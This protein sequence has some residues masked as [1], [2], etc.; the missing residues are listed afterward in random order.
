MLLTYKNLFARDGYP[1][2]L[3]LGSTHQR[4]TSG[5]PSNAAFARFTC[6]TT[7]EGYFGTTTEG[8]PNG[9]IPPTRRIS[10]GWWSRIPQNYFDPPVSWQKVIYINRSTALGMDRPMVSFGSNQ[11]RGFYSLTNNTDN[12]RMSVE[13]DFHPELYAGQWFHT[14]VYIDLDDTQLVGLTWERDGT[15][16]TVLTPGVMQMFITTLDGVYRNTR[17]QREVVDSNLGDFISLDFLGGYAQADPNGRK[18][19]DLAKMYVL[20]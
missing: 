5:G 17:V 4:F 11:I 6:S 18:A 15:P 19:I 12:P 1:L 20:T 3:S 10:M 13:V 7:T 14:I 2:K 9:D 8:T 16:H